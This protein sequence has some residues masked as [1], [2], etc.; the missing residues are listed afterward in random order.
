MVK[1]NPTDVPTEV[2]ADAFLCSDLRMISAF[3]PCFATKKFRLKMGRFSLYV[4]SY[5]KGDYDSKEVPT[6]VPMDVP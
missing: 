1:E 4:S 6:D 3:K 2:P 5:G